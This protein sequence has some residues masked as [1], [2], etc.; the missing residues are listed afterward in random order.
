MGHFGKVCRQPHPSTCQG[1][2]TPQT[3]N[4]QTSTLTISD[5]SLIQLSELAHGSIV[6]A[7]TINMQVATCNGQASLEILP[8]SGADICAAGPQFVH[9]LGEN[10]DNLA[11]SQVSPRAVN[12]S[13]LDPVGMIPN[14]SFCTNGKTIQ[15]NVHI[16]ASVT[17]ALISWRTAQKLGILPS[18][19]PSPIGQIN[20]C[21]GP[22]LTTEQLMSEF[23]SVFDGQILARNPHL[24]DRW[25]P[26]ILCE[27]TTH[28]SFCISGQTQTRA[29]PSRCPRCHYTRN[30]A[31]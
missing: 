5:L 3:T 25:C 8:D 18:C 22:L 20:T 2:T 1:P 11:H 17:G 31:N 26:P 16:Y 14:V 29:R 12:G 19:Y 13:I 30:R 9:S 24:L 4:P 15:D 23:P 27:C 6:P 7:P 28:Y 10:M 21:H